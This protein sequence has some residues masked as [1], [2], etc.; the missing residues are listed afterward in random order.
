[1]VD[2]GEE[3]L[4]AEVRGAEKRGGSVAQGASIRDKSAEESNFDR[5]LR[6]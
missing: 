6:G 5:G 4:T 3:E 1:M 2:S